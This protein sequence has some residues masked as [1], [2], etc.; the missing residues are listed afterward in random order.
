MLLPSSCSLRAPADEDYHTAMIGECAT[1]DYYF[2][3]VLQ[4]LAPVGAD[5]I[6]MPPPDECALT[7]EKQRVF[8]KDLLQRGLERGLFIQCIDNNIYAYRSCR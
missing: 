2:N 1:S 7:Y 5:V 6:P 3:N 8:V 4:L